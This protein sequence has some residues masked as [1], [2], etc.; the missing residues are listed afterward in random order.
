MNKTGGQYHIKKILLC[1]LQVSVNTWK[2]IKESA[3]NTYYFA[4][5][6]NATIAE[7]SG[8]EKDVPT[9]SLTHVE[10]WD[11]EVCKINRYQIIRIRI[12]YTKY[13]L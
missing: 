8:A 10:L 12:G 5:R 13:E 6:V 9:T 7:A 1:C 2:T 11:V 3:A 4:W